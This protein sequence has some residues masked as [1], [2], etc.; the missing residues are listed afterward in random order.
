M[1]KVSWVQNPVSCLMCVFGKKYIKKFWFNNVAKNTA[2]QNYSY[3]DFFHFL[4]RFLS[5]L[6][7]PGAPQAYGNISTVCVC[8]CVSSLVSLSHLL[9]QFTDFYKTSQEH[10]SDGGHPNALWFTFLRLV[11]SQFRKD[12]HLRQRTKYHHLIYIHDIDHMEICR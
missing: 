1:F 11:L 3:S 9:Y 2:R 8:L 5:F 7:R 12:K 10:F 4:I 6:N